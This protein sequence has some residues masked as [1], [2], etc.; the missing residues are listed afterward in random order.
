MLEARTLVAEL[1]AKYGELGITIDDTTGQITGFTVAQQK[2]NKA[3]RERAVMDIDKALSEA[4]ANFKALQ[5][6]LKTVELAPSAPSTPVS[7]ILERLGLIMTP[8]QLRAEAKG[9]RDRIIDAMKEMVKD[10]EILK[11]R[12][13]AVTEGVIE[14]LTGTEPTPGVSTHEVKVEVDVTAVDALEK[15]LREIEQHPLDVQV[16]GIET[17]AIELPDFGDLKSQLMNGLGEMIGAAGTFQHIAGL[18]A[19]DAAQRVA[20]AAEESVQLELQ[21]LRALL[22]RPEMVFSA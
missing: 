19:G 4:R 1:T 10:I 11:L 20:V 15:R 2:L 13:E 9:Q 5:S 21:I 22:A 6:Q 3:L 12:R 8:E 14:A 7:G 16:G 17:P 18:G